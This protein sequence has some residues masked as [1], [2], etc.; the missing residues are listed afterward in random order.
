[1]TSQVG[2]SD[3]EYV[4]AADESDEAWGSYVIDFSHSARL[5]GSPDADDFVTTIRGK[6]RYYYENQDRNVEAG[7][8]S[9]YLIQGDHA[10][11]RGRNL[12]HLCDEHSQFIVDYAT[13]LLSPKTGD[14]K[15]GVDRQ[16][17]GVIGS[18][19]LVLDKVEIFP[20][21]RGKDLGLAVGCSFLDRFGADSG[22]AIL[23]PLPLQSKESN[24]DIREDAQWR[25]TMQIDKFETNEK[26]ALAKLRNYWKRLG[27]EQ[28]KKSK[29][30]ALN[31]MHD[32]PSMADLFPDGILPP[33]QQ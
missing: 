3:A 9:G 7:R 32:R 2:P 24:R 17:G 16:L 10:C 25:A 14:I 1:M 18:N 23:K 26:L 6:I 22:V 5:T 27:F 19:I 12:W 13:E 20:G 15:L 21:H 33:G 8:L 4:D 31:L 30:F 11:D 28:L 29:C